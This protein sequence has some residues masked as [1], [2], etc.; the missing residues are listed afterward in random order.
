MSG[1]GQGLPDRQLTAASCSTTRRRSAR[2][3]GSATVSF[4]VVG[5]LASKGANMIGVDQDDILLAPWTTIRYRVTAPRM[6]E[7]TEL[8]SRDEVSNTNRLYPDPRPPSSRVVVDDEP[9]RSG[10]PG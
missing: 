7:V 10:P 2:R 9:Q 1:W 5:L 3:S 8:S 6:A 4:K